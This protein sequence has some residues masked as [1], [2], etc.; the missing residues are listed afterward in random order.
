MGNLYRRDFGGQ[1]YAVVFE[2]PD[3]SYGLLINGEFTEEHYDTQTDA[4]SAAWLPW[5]EVL[6][7][8]PYDCANRSA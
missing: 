8:R 6:S 1:F 5:A 4:K 3:K 2:Y 7:R